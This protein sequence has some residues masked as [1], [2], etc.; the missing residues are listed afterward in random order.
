[1]RETTSLMT[2][3]IEARFWAKVAQAT[4]SGCWIWTAARK[5]NGYGVLGAVAGRRN[6]YA[7]RLSWEI[8]FGLIPKGLL[9]CHHCDNRPCVN[10]DHL[11]LG[12]QADN[13]AD[14]VAKGRS[15]RGTRHNMARLSEAAVRE[16]R[17]LWEVGGLTQVEIG[18]RFG[19]N[20]GLVSAIVRG[21][22]WRH[23]LPSDWKSPEPN[24]W[25]RPCQ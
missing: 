18:I 15:L 24:S 20:K 22:T 2:P 6:A 7:H 14:M 3:A 19:V 12:T 5:E 8:H 9:V 4:P 17:R 25:S 13:Q 16:I 23:L 11:F 10:P 1:M 21:K